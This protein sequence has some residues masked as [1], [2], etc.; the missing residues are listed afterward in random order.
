MSTP[1]ANQRQR[2]S[3]GG[4]ALML[5]GVLLALLSGVLVIFIVSQATSSAGQT[6]QIV[7]A[8]QDIPAN[9]VLTTGASNPSLDELN[10]QAAFTV[11]SYPVAL[12][13]PGAYVYST[14]DNLQANLN[15]QVVV[16][17][18]PS[19]DVLRNPDNRLQLVGST[20]AVGS[21]ASIS[22]SKLKSG[23]VLFSFTYNNPLGSARGLVVAGDYIDILATECNLPG[24]SGACI[25]Q[26]TL[27]NLYVY[28][29][30][31]NAVV[32]VLNH[33]NV[34]NLKYLLETGKIDL[35]IRNPG[36]SGNNAPADNTQPVT[37]TSISN[38][39]GF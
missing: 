30:F 10:I 28:A 27:Q 2:S 13:P 6:E 5:L 37:A 14:L 26:T 15:N 11:K 34:L 32:V 29:T 21:L 17:D 24:S 7:V 1:R 38:T 36:D 8:A 22:P 35:A 33:Q 3:G 12:V 16:T 18:I 19:G 31:S 25:T 23:D 4:R 9:T 20:A 39:F